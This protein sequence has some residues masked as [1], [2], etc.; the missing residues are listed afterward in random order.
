MCT[1]DFLSGDK[2]KESY[3][4]SIKHDKKKSKQL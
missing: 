2:F 1:Q 4:Y 3:I